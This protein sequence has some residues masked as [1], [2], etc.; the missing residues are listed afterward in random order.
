MACMYSMQ[1]SL[2]IHDACFSAICSILVGK[3]WMRV[4]NWPTL[5]FCVGMDTSASTS[6]VLKLTGCRGV[7]CSRSIDPLPGYWS[8]VSTSISMHSHWEICFNRQM[9]LW[10]YMLPSTWLYWRIL[11]KVLL[12]TGSLKML[13]CPCYAVNPLVAD[14]TLLWI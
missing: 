7:D 9:L 4:I 6:V 1:L 2:T 8:L 11:W 13:A 14:T 10:E 3:K 5:Q 12:I